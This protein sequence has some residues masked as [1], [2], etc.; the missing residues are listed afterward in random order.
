[1]V[2]GLHFGHL[3]F[4]LRGGNIS[5]VMISNGGGDPVINKVFQHQLFMTA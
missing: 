3:M 4:G 2:C 1:M 5:K